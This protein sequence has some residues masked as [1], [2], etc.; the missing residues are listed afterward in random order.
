[1]PSV[2]ENHLVHIEDGPIFAHQSISEFPVGNGLNV[3][4]PEIPV[5]RKMIRI[6]LANA[7]EAGPDPAHHVPLHGD[8]SRKTIFLTKGS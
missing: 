8:L 5:F 3:G 7:G 2:I 6:N 4:R 1:M